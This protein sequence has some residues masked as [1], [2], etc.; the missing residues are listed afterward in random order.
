MTSLVITIAIWIIIPLAYIVYNLYSKNK[1]MESIILY[2][3]EFV[4][5]FLGMSKQF[6]EMTNKI[7][8]TMW[9]QSDPELMQLFDQIKQIKTILDN[10]E[11]KI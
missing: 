6:S 9:V 3:R 2:Q 5:E 8:M 11:E 10:Y 1:R 7:E 4:R